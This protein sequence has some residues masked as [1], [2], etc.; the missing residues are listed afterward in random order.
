ML[1]INNIINMYIQNYGFCKSKHI[2][3]FVYFCKHNVNVVNK[4]IR[5]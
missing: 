2:M 4:E 5:I 3:Y 1:I